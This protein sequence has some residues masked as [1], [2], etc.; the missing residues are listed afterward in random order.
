MRE[1]STATYIVLIQ[2]YILWNISTTLPFVG[3]TSELQLR[4][5]VRRRKEKGSGPVGQG[6]DVN[7]Y[8][9]FLGPKFAASPGKGGLLGHR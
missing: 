8:G 2:I 9:I 3:T 6:T 5:K 4:C 1:D 7:T